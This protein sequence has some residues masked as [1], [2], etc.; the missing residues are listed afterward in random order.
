[1]NEPQPVGDLTEADAPSWVTDSQRAGWNYAIQHAPLGLL[2]RLDKS[3]LVIWVCAEDLHRRAV[4]EVAR[5]GMLLKSPNTGEPIQSP[6][7]GIAS[8]QATM[9]MQAAAALGF[10]P[11][12]RPQIAAPHPAN[13]FANN[14]RRLGR[15]IGTSGTAKIRAN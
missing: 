12:A 3:I 6:Y 1:M 15:V 5:L 9:M 13:V 2:K 11:A 8:R 4:Q 7:I 10:S 14:G